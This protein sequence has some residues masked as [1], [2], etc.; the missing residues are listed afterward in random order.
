M[1]LPSTSAQPAASGIEPRLALKRLTW[2]F[3]VCYFLI[4]IVLPWWADR[5][6]PKENVALLTAS[7][8]F[9]WFYPDRSTLAAWT[10]HA[11][12][13]V[14]PASVAATYVLG[15][16]YISAMLGSAWL[17]AREVMD[18]R[19]AMLTVL[20]ITC[21]TYYTN[22]LH[23]FSDNT[24]LTAMT[25]IAVVSL[26][27]A[28]RTQEFGWWIATGVFWG[29]GLLAKPLMIVTIACGVVA[30]VTVEPRRDRPSL[31]SVLC[32]LAVCMVVICPALI[33]YLQRTEAISGSQYWR[34][35]LPLL[36]RPRRLVD[37]SADQ[38]LRLVPL[39]F[40]IGILLRTRSW[41]VGGAAQSATP[42]SLKA[43][44]FLAIYAWGPVI[45]ILAL[46]L[47]GVDLQAPWGTAF[48]WLLPVWFVSTRRGARFASIDFEH[49]LVCVALTH[50]V[51]VVGYVL[52]W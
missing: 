12:F 49:V 20:F 28:L 46:G 36:S 13:T 27:R 50:V 35:L 2:L 23:F 18:R 52:D 17:M 8:T 21:C 29:L 33:A 43:R 51:M 5:Q 11:V 38:L 30:A 25:A 40:L 7:R 22:R 19:R 16:L 32:A 26:W 44:R 42:P 48:L 24:A 10:A 34:D 39:L 3:V 37:F 14:V 1:T 9:A 47:L 31:H 41:Q 4:W 6:P 45:A 15:A